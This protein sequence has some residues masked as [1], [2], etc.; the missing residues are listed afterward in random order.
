MYGWYPRGTLAIIQTYSV[1]ELVSHIATPL[2]ATQTLEYVRT[3]FHL[4]T[5][6]IRLIRF[7]DMSKDVWSEAP[8]ISREVIA[9]WEGPGLPSSFSFIDMAAA[10]YILG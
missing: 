7:R 3:S 1:L 9:C 8:A 10:M 6:Q 4:K 5:L 2:A